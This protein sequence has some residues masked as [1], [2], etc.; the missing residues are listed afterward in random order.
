MAAR[1][2]AAFAFGAKAPR[3]AFTV[4]GLPSPALLDPVGDE[5]ALLRGYRSPRPSDPTRRGTKLAFGS[6][7]WR[8]P[9]AH[10][11]RGL[12]AWP[13][14][15]RHLHLT[16]SLD[17]AAVSSGSL[18]LKGALL[19][20]SIGLGADVFAFHRIPVSLQGGVGRGLNRDG[21]TVPW[22][23]IGFPF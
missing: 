8:I 10:P 6:L 18:R 22:F 11:Q 2:G 9:L 14:F 7:D 12:G 13:L 17:A 20:A 23:S 3:N 5:P 4:G 21:K 15:L 19:G 1:L 16:T